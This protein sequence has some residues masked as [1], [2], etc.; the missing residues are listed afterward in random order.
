MTVAESSLPWKRPAEPTDMPLQSTVVRPMAIGPS[1][2][3]SGS[4][5]K[6]SLIRD[7][8]DPKV[9]DL[10]AGVSNEGFVDSQFDFEEEGV[11]KR[12]TQTSRL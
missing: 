8:Y 4:R 6:M 1:I 9:S 11:K 12:K 2:A 10:G 3:H 5:S 7:D